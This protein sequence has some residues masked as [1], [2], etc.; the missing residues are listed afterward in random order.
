MSRVV[1]VLA[2]GKGERAGEGKNKLLA[3]AGGAPILAHTV[4]RF[5]GLVDEIVIV[6]SAADLEAGLLSETVVRAWGADRIV[7]GGATRAE[8]ARAGYSATRGHDLIGFHDGARPFVDRSDIE[9]VYD[10]AEKYG[11]AVLVAPV[12]DTVKEVVGGRVAR[13][14]GREGLR[15]ALTP[16]VMRAGVAERAFG[17]AFAA[18]APDDVWLVERLGL[19]VAA[20]EGAATN[21][22]LTTSEEMAFAKRLLGVG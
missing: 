18:D 7:V 16:Q 19:T 14:I 12:A 6:A 22:K 3:E 8:S 10:A 1:L 4:G 9:A 20:V 13:T 11:A 15:R 21:L 17:E 2:A 5:T